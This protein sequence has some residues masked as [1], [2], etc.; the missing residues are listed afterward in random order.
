VLTE[1]ETAVRDFYD[2]DEVK[3]VYYSEVE[4]LIKRI[5][6][7]ERVVVFDHIVRN[8]VLAERGEKGCGFS[9][10]NPHEIF[11]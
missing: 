9:K 7:A 5:T 6:G 1:H 8:P 10:L 3:S 4:H 11:C 2:P